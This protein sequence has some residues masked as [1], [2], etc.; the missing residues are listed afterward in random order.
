MYSFNVSRQS[1]ARILA[2]NSIGRASPVSSAERARR[3][4]LAALPERISRKA[5]SGHNSRNMRR[6]PL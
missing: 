2:A 1:Q 4:P 5:T 6:A 3:V